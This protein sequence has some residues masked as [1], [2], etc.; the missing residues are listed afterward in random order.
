MRGR[1]GCKDFGGDTERKTTGSERGKLYIGRFPCGSSR[2]PVSFI[3]QFLVSSFFPVKLF[4][5][6]PKPA[7][8]SP[9]FHLNFPLSRRICLTESLDKLTNHD[10]NCQTK[11]HSLGNKSII[12]ACQASISVTLKLL[13]KEKSMIVNVLLASLKIFAVNTQYSNYRL[14]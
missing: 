10:L 7:S 2:S 4:V 9:R 1:S 14:V 3:P 6:L 8:V 11:L 12:N 13:Q 5:G